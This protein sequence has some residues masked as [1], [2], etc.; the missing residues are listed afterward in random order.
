MTDKEI[1]KIYL[2]EHLTIDDCEKLMSMNYGDLVIPIISSVLTLP[3]NLT[4]ERDL[5]V[6]T[7]S[8]DKLPANLTVGRDLNISDTLIE[9]LPDDI[10]VGHSI[11]AVHSHIREI[12]IAH[13]RGGLILAETFHI[14]TLPDGLKVDESLDL[15]KS[16]IK[17][18][19]SGLRCRY[20]NI[21]QTKIDELPED[22]VVEKDIWA[23][24][25][26][27]SDFRIRCVHGFLDLDHCHKLRSLPD[28]L[29]VDGALD[30]SCSGISRLPSGMRVHHL[31]ISHTDID[32][33]P[34]DI[35]VNGAI[36]ASHTRIREFH[37]RRVNGALNLSHCSQLKKLP[38]EL[39]VGAMFDIRCSAVK[40]LPNTLRVGGTMD[41]RYTWVHHI[42]DNTIAGSIVH[43][44]GVTTIG[45][46]VTIV[47]PLYVSRQRN[48]P[49]LRIVRVDNN[50]DTCWDR[51]TLK[52]YNDTV[53]D[54]IRYGRDGDSFVNYKTRFMHP[55]VKYVKGRYLYADGILTPIKSTHRL[56]EYTIFNGV[57]KDHI[58]ISDGENYAHCCSIREGINDLMFK[59]DKDRVLDQ[60]RA[61]SLDS[62]V[63]KDFAITMYRNITGACKQGTQ[64]F[65]DS[66]GDNIKAW[67]TIG[68]IIEL[69]DGHYGSETFREFFS[70]A[71]S[72]VESDN[73]PDLN[74][75]DGDTICVMSLE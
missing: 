34:M 16:C 2:K 27:I 70:D 60:Y 33:L 13:V 38:D 12:N 20:L 74:D 40:E 22:I 75:F 35:I 9:S 72:E 18:L 23:S 47:G 32:E 53:I 68:E 58:V 26:N 66:L 10:S 69:T 57:F 8:I 4:V 52:V 48:Y 56:G 11:I 6:E 25:T 55:T 14:E 7:L 19:P 37:I 31:D 42:P 63:G 3:D 29:T 17:C 50:D 73:I 43:I 71:E 51:N 59:R 36:D 64:M 44:D 5:I 61:L 54:C 1:T 62:A 30:V 45:H 41:I 65:L 39:Y 28:G 15:R 24:H 49:P 67:Y 21:K 46:N